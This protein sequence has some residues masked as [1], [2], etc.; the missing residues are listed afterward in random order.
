MLLLLAI[1]PLLLLLVGAT[2]QQHDLNLELGD[3]D[4]ALL[5]GIAAC[6]AGARLDSLML[7]V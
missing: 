1:L 7:S 5:D 3:T 6:C 4:R 2:G